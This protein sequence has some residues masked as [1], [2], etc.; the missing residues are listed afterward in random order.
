MRI[1]AQKI[2]NMLQHRYFLSI[3][4]F[5]IIL[6][7]AVIMALGFYAFFSFSPPIDPLIGESNTKQI[8]FDYVYHVDRTFYFLTTT[9]GILLGTLFFVLIL[10]ALQ[11]Y[12][13]NIDRK[14]LIVWRDAG[15]LCEHLEILPADRL[16]INNIEIQ[17]NRT[18][19]DTLK[20]LL[21]KRLEG[22]PL[23]AL[24]IGEHGIQSIKRLREELGAKF[25]EKV[26]IKVNKGQ[27]YWLEVDPSSIKVPQHKAGELFE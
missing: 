4:S 6:S 2:A 10:L 12:A 13:W 25:L 17:L 3:I 9:I 24:D 22:V 26:F 1:F 19:L 20:K 16:R 5:L 11:M 27:G 8:Y 15:F 14:R 21:L 7:T 23:H 18:Q